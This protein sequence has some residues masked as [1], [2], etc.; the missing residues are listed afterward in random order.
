M[1]F[2]DSGLTSEI[3]RYPHLATWNRPSRTNDPRPYPVPE[4][5]PVEDG[6]GFDPDSRTVDLRKIDHDADEHECAWWTIVEMCL[7]IDASLPSDSL[8]VFTIKEPFAL[9]DVEEEDIAEADIDYTVIGM[10]AISPFPQAFILTDE[11]GEFDRFEGKGMT[12]QALRDRICSKVSDRIGGQ[13]RWNVR[14][15][16]GGHE[17]GVTYE[18]ES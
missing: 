3:L 4:Y 5:G 13:G 6:Y 11:A 14:M 10:D 2:G 8:P 16:L 17:I 18:I 1:A 15:T 7:G 9:E 12:F